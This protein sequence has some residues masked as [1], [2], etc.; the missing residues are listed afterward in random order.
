M[1]LRRIITHLRK[2]EW[3]V[4]RIYSTDAGTSE[5]S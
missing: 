4:F 2:Q 1:I 3:A 5:Y